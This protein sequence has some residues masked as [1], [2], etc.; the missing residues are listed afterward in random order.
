MKKFILTLFSILGI[1]VAFGQQDPLYSQYLLNPFIIN[2][3]YAGFTNNI[4][5]LVANRSQWAGLEGRPITSNASMHTALNQNKMGLGVTAL[6]DEIGTNKTTEVHLA[7]AY[8]IE[9]K[10]KDRISF[11]L[12][13][14][15]VNYKN[16]FSKL[17]IDPNDPKFQANINETTFS[18]GAG[19]IYSSDR[20]MA[21]ISV[22][23]M[24]SAK[25]QINGSD[26][27]LYNQHAYGHATYSFDLTHQIKVKPFVMVRYVKGAAI[28]FDAGGTFTFRD[29]YSIGLFTRRLHTIGLLA[30][31]N[32]GDMLRIGYVFELPTSKSSGLNY[33]AHEITLGIQTK[34]FRFHE[35]NSVEDF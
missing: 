30:K 22:P 12:H 17:T 29:S 10:N 25:A 4:T 18:F 6:K 31:L 2:P 1:S 3:A 27:V 19:I 35:L 24:L 5:A 16:D 33:T 9:M 20:W 26:I 21:G 23:K 8:R 32:L 14:G 15:G 13:A 7:Y 34:L 28:N 11:G